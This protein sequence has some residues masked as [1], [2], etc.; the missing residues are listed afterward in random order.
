MPW[1]SS[2]RKASVTTTIE[3]YSIAA[4]SCAAA[5][6]TTSPE[7]IEADAVGLTARP[8]ETHV[9][10]WGG[11]LPQYAVGHLDRVARIRTAVANVPG[12]AVCGAAYDGVGV[13]AV[14]GS[15]HRAVADLAGTG[16]MEP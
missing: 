12:L 9:Q 11:G 5:G 6:P 16:T 14:I 3:A 4:S 1:T 2:T 13:P 15:A 10:R 7:R 8:V